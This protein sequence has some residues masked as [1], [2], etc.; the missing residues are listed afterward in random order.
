MKK[1]LSHILLCGGS[2]YLLFMPLVVSAEE[3]SAKSIINDSVQELLRNYATHNITS[4]MMAETALE[5]GDKL[6]NQV[7]QYYLE[8]EKACNERFFVNKCIEES[9]LQRR[10]WQDQIRTITQTAKAYIRQ[11]KNASKLKQT[12]GHS[13]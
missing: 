1:I 2:V 4:I 6:Q 12:E 5:R 7:Q 8:S 9:R 10:T 11:A 3:N 13:N